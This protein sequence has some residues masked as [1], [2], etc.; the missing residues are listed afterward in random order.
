M[1]VIYLT[2]NRD[3][4]TQGNY[5]VDWL[6]AFKKR[7]PNMVIYGPGYETTLDESRF[8]SLWTCI[9]GVILTKKILLFFK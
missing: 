3:N 8:Y 7:F 5:Y 6:N 4:Y 1:N 2:D 9:Y